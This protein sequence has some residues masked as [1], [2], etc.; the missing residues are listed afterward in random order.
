MMEY[1][2]KARVKLWGRAKVLDMSGPHR[3]IEFRVEA[4]DM[5]CSKYLP[6]YFTLATV[7]RTTEKLTARIA[8]LEAE[9]AQLKS[10]T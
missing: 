3:A 6:D 1:E 4:W 10:D 7:R 2:M 5:N 8:E 9:L